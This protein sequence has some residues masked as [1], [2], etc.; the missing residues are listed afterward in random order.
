MRKPTVLHDLTPIQQEY[1]RDF[2]HR[3]FVIP[4]GRRSRKT[5]LGIA[6]IEYIAEPVDALHVPAD[7]KGMRYYFVEC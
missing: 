3:F 4:A 7:L 2:E 5:L 1:Y 6:K